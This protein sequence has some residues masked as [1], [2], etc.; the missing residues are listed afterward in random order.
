MSYGIVFIFLA[1]VLYTVGVW[2]EKIQG[3]LKL[4]HLFLFWLGIICD[5]VGTSVM[6]QISKAHLGSSG[7]LHYVPLSSNFHSLTGILALILM[8]L[9]TSWATLII[10]YNK[11]S[12]I[13]K[14]HRYS[15][16]VWLVWLLPFISGALLHMM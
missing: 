13:I 11:E 1:F 14:F 3:R 2:S 5:F 15:L 8:L 10:V 12:W 4:G 6:E 16:S 9:H 7:L